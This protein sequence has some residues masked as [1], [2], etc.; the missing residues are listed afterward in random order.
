[1]KKSIPWQAKVQWL[2]EHKEL[3]WDL[4]DSHSKQNPQDVI[5]E[6]VAGLRTAGL[7]ASKSI[8]INGSTILRLMDKARAKIREDKKLIQK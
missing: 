8:V 7:Y 5:D 3:W 4:G 2:V 1:M 6:V